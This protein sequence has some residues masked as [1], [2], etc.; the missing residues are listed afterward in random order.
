[1]DP[2]CHSG[3]KSLISPANKQSILDNDFHICSVQATPLS[4]A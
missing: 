1:M 2:L 4:E 3:S